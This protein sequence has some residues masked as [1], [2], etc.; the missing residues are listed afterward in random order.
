[1]T[2]SELTN[3]IVLLI[4]LRLEFPT[5]VNLLK[6]C[7]TLE[8]YFNQEWLWKLYVLKHVP[9]H[10][11][12]KICR[13]Q[14]KHQLI[15]NNNTEIDKNK[16]NFPYDFTFKNELR[17][18]FGYWQWIDKIVTKKPSTKILITKPLSTINTIKLI[19]NKKIPE[20]KCSFAISFKNQNH[21]ELF[22]LGYSSD[23]NILP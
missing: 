9:D 15:K 5:F 17:N 4:A 10:N 7:S 13:S 23:H 12:I 21:I 8:T 19:I 18:F 11:I 20:Q 2:F 3:E 14:Y 6:T 22:K 1:M 16:K